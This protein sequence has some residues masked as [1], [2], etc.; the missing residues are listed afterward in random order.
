MLQLTAFRCQFH[1]TFD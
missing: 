1:F